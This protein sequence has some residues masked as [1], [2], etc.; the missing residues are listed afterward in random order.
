MIPAVPKPETASGQPGDAAGTAQAGKPGRGPEAIDGVVSAAAQPS[1][2]TGQP[3]DGV[4]G[5]VAAG[6]ADDASP[7]GPG[8]MAEAKGGLT[9]SP[10]GATPAPGQ[11]AKAAEAVAPWTS[12]AVGKGKPADPV[13]SSLPE[14]PAA[15]AEAGLGKSAEAPAFTHAENSGSMAEAAQA[16]SRDDAVTTPTEKLFAGSDQASE[17]HQARKGMVVKAPSDA[18]EV[19]DRAGPAPVTNE[20]GHGASQG[21]AARKDGATGRDEAPQGTKLATVSALD[22][23][24]AALPVALAAADREEPSNVPAHHHDHEPVGPRGRHVTAAHPLLQAQP[25]AEA[26]HHG[27]EHAGFALSGMHKDLLF[28]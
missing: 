10:G 14:K 27:A 19:A 20:A 8:A 22:P 17:T 2:P 4:K 1:R 28:A 7:G 26:A 13:A 21:L 15:G 24:Q 23:D 16:F 9:E 5:S 3:G 25:E 12:D 18:I 11:W 6:S